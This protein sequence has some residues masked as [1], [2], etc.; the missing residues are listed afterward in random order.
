MLTK[1]LYLEIDKPNYVPI[2]TVQYD[3]NSR[4]YEITIL[5][6][7]Q[8][9]DLTGI[10][11]IVAGKK[12]DGKDVFN[13]CKVL[14]AKKGIIQLELTEQMNAVNGASE[15]ALELFSADGMLS[16]QPFKLIV[17]RSII[18][19][20]VESSKELGAL[21]DALNEVQDIDNRFAQTNAQLSELA[22][23]GTTVE[24]LERVTKEEIDRQIADGTMANLSIADNSIT[25]AK[26]KDNSV[27]TEKIKD[28]S[29]TLAKLGDDVELEPPAKSVTMEKTDFFIVEMHNLFDKNRVI[30][31]IVTGDDLNT[32]TA[33]LKTNYFIEVE[34][35]TKYALKNTQGDVGYWDKSKEYITRGVGGN[36]VITTPENCYY[37]KITT[38][39]ALV[40]TCMMV[41]GDK[42]PTEYQPYG[43]YSVN[44]PDTELKKAIGE[45]ISSDI[46]MD[47]LKP[48]TYDNLDFIETVHY[49][50][51]NEG[52]SESGIVAAASGVIIGNVNYMASGFMPVEVGI[53]YKCN[54]TTFDCA[55]FDK[56]KRY[57]RSAVGYNNTNLPQE[58]D[59]Y[60]RISYSVKDV[61][62]IMF[63]KEERLPTEYEPYGERYEIKFSKEEDAKSLS[64]QL[65]PY[66]LS[67]KLMGKKWCFIGDSISDTKDGRTRTTKF[68]SE[69]IRDETGVELY[70]W[71]GNG[72][73]YVKAFGGQNG[74]IDRL[75][76]IPADTDIITI[77]AGTND[78]VAIGQLGDT[79]RDTF[80]GAVD[81]VISGIINRFPTASFGVMTIL[82][83]GTNEDRLN[84]YVRR[85]CNAIIDVCKKYGVP[86]L[87]LY[88]EIGFFPQNETFATNFMPDKL[89]PNYNGHERMARKIKPWL[90]T[91]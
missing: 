34:P 57:T 60:I 23:K 59:A 10:R 13:S 35:N 36:T 78:N 14:D 61:G 19:K 50:L 20:S 76:D 25:D 51:L 81:T 65:K 42:I 55:Y 47:K 87:N 39:P 70:N 84:N 91:L 6:N 26:L 31:G 33:Y 32:N 29:V 56:N 43:V 45:S 48:L 1:S 83:K 52:E 18:S 40:D 64:N 88:D 90:E 30:A 44:I 75:D 37:M 79:S 69:F 46:V 72:T 5:N 7:S 11:V 4:F 67:S 41:K 28:K 8:P 71:N 85:Q 3:Y 86:V 12:P 53:K 74:I 9:L 89:H 54:K 27:V 22:S 15:Y 38:T 80:Y 62:S 16:S 17:T 63:A 77:L 68:Y 2:Y 21:K 58:G 73:G 66:I 82:P 49:N 24:V